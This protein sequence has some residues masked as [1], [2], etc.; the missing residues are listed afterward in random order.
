[1]M[2]KNRAENIHG[3]LRYF[4][5]KKPSPNEKANVIAINKKTYCKLKTFNIAESDV[6]DQIRE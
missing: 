3:I 5:N 2:P 6:L 4:S 1:M